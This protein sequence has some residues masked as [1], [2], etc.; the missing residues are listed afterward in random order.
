LSESWNNNFIGGYDKQIE[1]RGLQGGGL[2]PTIDIK[3]DNQCTSCYRIYNRELK[4]Y[5]SRSRSF[6]SRNKL[7][8][9]TLHFT[10][11]VTKTIA[12][13]LFG[14]NYEH[15]KSSNLFFSGSNGVFIFNS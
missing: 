12:P 7:S 3:M 11:N 8:Y 10:D 2:F 5:F 1:D 6:Y 15:F 13:L 14:A 4:F 9:S